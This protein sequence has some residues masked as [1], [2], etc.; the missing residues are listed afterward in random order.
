MHPDELKV[1]N[2]QE[3]EIVATLTDETDACDG[4]MCN[5]GSFASCLGG[6]LAASAAESGERLACTVQFVALIFSI[7]LCVAGTIIL[8]CCG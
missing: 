2:T 3:K 1:L 8:N 6:I 4:V 5:D 7:V